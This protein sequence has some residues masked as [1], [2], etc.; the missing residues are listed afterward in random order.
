MSNSVISKGFD[1]SLTPFQYQVLQRIP[2]SGKGGVLYKLNLSSF[3]G[4]STEDVKAACAYLESQGL[5]AVSSM[6]VSSGNLSVE[7]STYGEAFV[8]G[9]IQL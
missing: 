7:R 2:S 4:Y 3:A 5:I 8:K 1:F 9:V 6:F